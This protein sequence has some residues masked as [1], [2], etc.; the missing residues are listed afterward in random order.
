MMDVTG[1]G[2][3]AE[4]GKSVIS[5]IWPDPK[6]QAD[7]LYRLSEL[8]Q[9]GD[10]AELNAHVQ[11][12]LGQLEINKA[13]ADHPSVFVSGWRPAVGWVC[14]ASLALTFIPK[15]IVLTWVWCVAAYGA[16]N[17]PDF[18]DLGG[19]DIIT[20]LGSLLGVGILRSVDKFHG[21]DTK[22]QS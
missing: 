5:R 11:L 13:E 21:V 15:A 12:M 8:E 14:A 1:I 19:S 18:P 10:I 3:I 22:R 20:L 17:V 9:K 2:A 4:L 16:E 6:D 7:Q